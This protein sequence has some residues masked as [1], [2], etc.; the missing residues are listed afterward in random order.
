MIELNI[1]TYGYMDAVYYVINALA[2]FCKSDLYSALL[3]T[4]VVITGS[5]YG[6]RIAGATNHDAWKIYVGKIIGMMVVV[7]ALLMPTTNMMVIDNVTK[8]REKVDNVPIAF[9]VPVGII[10][11]FGQTIAQGFEQVFASIK[12]NFP[13]YE[14]GM[15]FGARL[16]KELSQVRIKD[17]EMVGNMQK[18]IKQCVAIPAMISYQFTKEE[19][20][21]TNDIWGLVSSKA[22]SLT[23]VDLSI[24]GNKE[25]LTC[26][27]A[28]RYFDVAFDKEEDRIFKKYAKTDFAK[29][30]KV[31][32]PGGLDLQSIDISVIFKKNLKSLY[33]NV[34]PA[35]DVL[36]Q[37]MM[38]N[39]IS[40]YS[41]S[42]Y[43]ISRARM[44]HETNSLLSGDLATLYLPMLLAVIKC[45]VYAA[46]IFLVPMLVISGGFA[47]YKSYLTLV[48][49]LQLWPAINAVINMIMATYSNLDPGSHMLISYSSAITTAKRA[50][51]IVTVAAGL[52]MLVPFLSLWLTQ[53]GQ[54][55]L[56]HL[57][58]S[59]MSSV[60]SATGMA[61]SELTTGNR[62]LDNVSIGNTTRHM[63]SGFKTDTNQQYVDGA[64][65]YQNKDGTMEKINR[66]GSIVLQGGAGITASSGEASYIL[67]DAVQT[68]L[69]E[70][71]TNKQSLGENMSRSVSNTK[72]Q[73]H[74]E[75]VNYLH[76]IGDHSR[77][78]KG[79][80]IDV[81]T[82]EGRAVSKALEDIDALNESNNY[83]WDQNARMY[84]DGGIQGGT[85]G[86]D[87]LGTGVYLKG[88]GEISAN[89]ASTQSSGDDS[90]ISKSTNSSTNANNTLRGL[91]S[92]SWAKEHN[93][94]K[95]LAE[96]YKK[97][98]EEVQR[99][100]SQMQKHYEEIEDYHKAIDYTKTQGSSSSKDIYQDVL[101]RHA[102]QS[103]K[104]IRSAKYDVDKKTPEVMQV[105]KELSNQETQTVLDN[106][107]ENKI[108]RG[109]AENDLE[110]FTRQHGSVDNKD[111]KAGVVKYA[112][113]KGFNMDVINRNIEDRGK[114]LQHQFN[115][116]YFS[117]EN[118]HKETNYKI[119]SKYVD[120][121]AEIKTLED[122]R[123]GNGTFS[124]AM[125]AAT[126]NPGLG[127]SWKLSAGRPEKN[128]K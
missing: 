57:A 55:G 119:Q 37:Q 75:A 28:V 85:P 100:E 107:R 27:D 77:T 120:R 43:A 52:Q 69:H 108:T 22:G 15:I 79:Y 38:V 5:Y 83:G 82:E 117:A 81:S 67:N 101:E 109:Q 124:A 33:D 104:D 115:Q 20:V 128:K 36:K 4:M 92:D 80:N 74:S 63:N 98:Y 29:A 73:M 121:K 96:D 70:G 94:D 3:K 6:L 126:Y 97:S 84:L 89:N 78:S 12:N 105:F 93:I 88:G 16:K 19:L 34:A 71:L 87:I 110:N 50:D 91:L 32:G 47:K 49:S 23:R 2:I 24:G 106:I 116:K 76:Q 99:A 14:Y 123:M 48:I 62:S 35:S 44:Q 64:Y 60:Q 46:F 51:T 41:S 30:G 31:L 65:S 127:K 25:Q 39:S 112:G 59:M 103:G 42:S 1:Y 26:K 53:L 102:L 40:D 56:M 61:A 118:L 10:E 9:A 13:Y 58:G 95:S 17:P 21:S 68:N 66:D 125:D 54:G 90:R 8:R 45:I 114:D 11:E 72:S 86:K 18:F 113:S 7:N 111:I 122:N